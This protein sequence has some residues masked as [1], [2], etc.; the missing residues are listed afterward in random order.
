MAISFDFEFTEL[1]RNSQPIS[2]GLHDSETDNCFYA[3][4]TDYPKDS[5]SDWIKDN[6]IANLTLVNQ[7]NNTSNKMINVHKAVEKTVCLYFR[8]HLKNHLCHLHLK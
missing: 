1:S 8:F 7:E 3:E 6:V 5:L 2:L 4:F